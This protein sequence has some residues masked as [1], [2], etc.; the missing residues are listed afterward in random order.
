MQ[1]N[2]IRTQRKSPA[3]LRAIRGIASIN[4]ALEHLVNTAWNFAYCALWNSTQ[5]STREMDAAKERICEYL[6]LARD[7]RRAFLTFCQRVLLARQYVRSGAGRYVPLPSIWLDK[8]YEAGFA[9]TKSWYTEIRIMRSSLP[10]F[11]AEIKALAEA[12][13]EFSEEP[14]VQNYQYWRTYFIDKEAPGLLQLFQVSAIHH[15]YN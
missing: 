9:G 12:V 11:K 1:A 8:D 5:F 13:L 3:K 6:T 15:L 10:N 7:P 14:T 4:P 2:T